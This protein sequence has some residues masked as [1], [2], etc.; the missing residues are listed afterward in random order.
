M[1]TR[2]P[3]PREEAARPGKSHTHNKR[4]LH[5][6]SLTN[7]GPPA[8]LDE[9]DGDRIETASAA[10]AD[11]SDGPVSRPTPAPRQQ[12]RFNTLPRVASAA[13]KG[14]RKLSGANGNAV[15]ERGFLY[16]YIRIV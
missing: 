9:D 6:T 8:A 14:R 5:A 3:P 16:Y 13:L 11:T 1:T 2:C 4:T 12:S 15:L 10:D 7:A